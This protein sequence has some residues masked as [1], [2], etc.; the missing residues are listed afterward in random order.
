MVIEFTQQ[1]RVSTLYLFAL[2]A[3]TIVHFI[4]TD[5][6]DSRIENYESDKIWEKI[7]KK[8]AEKAAA[9]AMKNDPQP[10]T[11]LTIW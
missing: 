8:D 6:I 9:A 2:A 4:I 11:G 1:F 3:I 7:E 5:L 10:E